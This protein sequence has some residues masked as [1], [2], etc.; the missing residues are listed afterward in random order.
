MTVFS[1]SSCRLTAVPG[2]WRVVH[3]VS[4]AG[5]S[6]LSWRVPCLFRSVNMRRSR[7]EGVESSRQPHGFAAGTG[8]VSHPLQAGII[9]EGGRCL[10]PAPRV[11]CGPAGERT[12]ARER[13]CLGRTSALR[14]TGGAAAEAEAPDV[15]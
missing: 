4:P 6:G 3:V 11:L 14:P 2:V 1:A 5:E 7:R 8:R 13:S 12:V 10:G 15:R 9:R